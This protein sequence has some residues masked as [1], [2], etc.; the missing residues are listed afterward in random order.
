MFFISWFLFINYSIFILK[1]FQSLWKT[2]LL[3]SLGFSFCYDEFR[4]R[5]G[6]VCSSISDPD[7]HW[8]GSPGSECVGNADPD[9]DPEARKLTKN[10]KKTWFPAFQTGFCTYFG[11]FYFY[12][13]IPTTK[14]IF[15]VKIQLFVT[16]RSD[17]DPDPHGS[18]SVWLSG[19]AL[20]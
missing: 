13:K 6:M 3:F 8:F 19:S 11:M 10:Y 5:H 17:Q 15:H 16:A 4:L 1:V 12:D 7:P 18:A 9:K 20:R 2:I 14:F